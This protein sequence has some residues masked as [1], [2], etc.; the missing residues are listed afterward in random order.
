MKVRPRDGQELAAFIDHYRRQIDRPDS[1]K[2][3]RIKEGGIIEFLYGSHGRT[4]Y[5]IDPAAGSMTRIDKRDIQPWHWLNRL[6]KAFKTGPAW[7]V[8]A[9]AAAL[10]ILLTTASGLLMFRYG[11]QDWLLLAAGCAILLLGVMLA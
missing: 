7:V 9:D 6:H 5:V 11:K 3:I 2:V 1:P 10:L 4:T 8:G